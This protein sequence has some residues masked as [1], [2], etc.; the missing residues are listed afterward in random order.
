MASATFSLRR[1][2]N[3]DRASTVTIDIG[4]SR[5]C[6]A[7]STTPRRGVPGGP[8]VVNTVPP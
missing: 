1:R 5:S 3:L 8:L 4:A 7:Y 2:E 6:I